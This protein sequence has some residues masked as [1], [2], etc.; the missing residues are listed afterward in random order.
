MKLAGSPA[1]ERLAQVL[2]VRV[3]YYAGT[4]NLQP[5]TVYRPIDGISPLSSDVSRLL[6]E[7]A[8]DDRHLGR[9]AAISLQVL[10]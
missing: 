8:P 2:I 9:G 7:R 10:S 6:I 4:Y 1:S 3:Q 5:F